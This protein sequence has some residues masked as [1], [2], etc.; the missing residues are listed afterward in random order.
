MNPPLQQDATLLT[1]W[2]ALAARIDQA[3]EA[4]GRPQGSV[5]LL[6]VSK[7]FDAQAVAQVHANGQQAFGEN[8]IQEGVQK[9]AEL[10]HLRANLEWHCIGP[11]QSNKT[12][13]VAEWFDWVQTIDRLKVA[14]R[15]ND[16]RPEGLP[17]LNVCIQVNVDRGLNKSGVAVEQAHELAHEVLAMPRLRLRGLMCIPDPVDGF[18]LQCER[19]ERAH[20]IYRHW[21]TL[22]DTVDTLSMGMSG[23]L[24]A[25]V[26]S[27]ST[28]V[29]VGS[30]LFGSRA[31]A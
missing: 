19:F 23:D 17:A 7:T 2:N 14:Q 4:A 12:R 5:R 9:I 31:A 21:Q 3:T 10:K 8:Y 26:A 1:R 25:A 11:V 13:Q 15:L 30:A 6:A 22:A 16:Q 28:M 24:E 20:A 18:E 27:G 29:R